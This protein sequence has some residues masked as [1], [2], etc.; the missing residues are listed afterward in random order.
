MRPRETRAVSRNFA[1][2]VQVS[3]Q[4]FFKYIE[5]QRRF[6]QAGSEFGRQFC[7]HEIYSI[8]GRSWHKAQGDQGCF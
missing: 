2:S 4:T 8:R 3:V 7:L 1:F 5:T 6:L